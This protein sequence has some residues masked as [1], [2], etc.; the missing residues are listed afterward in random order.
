MITTAIVKGI[1]GS[2]LA[3]IVTT[4][5][6]GVFVLN[7]AKDVD[8]GVDLLSQVANNRV[9][10]LVNA[11][12]GQLQVHLELLNQ[13]L[14]IVDLGNGSDI[15]PAIHCVVRHQ[16][17]D[18]N[19]VQANTDGVAKGSGQVGKD[20][21]NGK[22][23]VRDKDVVERVEEANLDF[24]AVRRRWPTIVGRNGSRNTSGKALRSGD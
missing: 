12:V 18:L 6:V 15:A 24:T 13:S 14:G 19:L 7:V 2:G 16:L 23:I 21:L 22:S 10:I 8:L 11:R 17:D 20:L 5:G 1:I 3:R 9:L 4:S